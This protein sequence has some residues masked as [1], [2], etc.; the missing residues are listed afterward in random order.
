[1]D[2]ICRRYGEQAVYFGLAVEKD[3]NIAVSIS[4]VN[5]AVSFY[6]QAPQNAAR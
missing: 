5:L 1:M 4:Y 3:K 2:R 6:K